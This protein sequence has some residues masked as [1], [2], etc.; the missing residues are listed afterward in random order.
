MKTLTSSADGFCPGGR[1]LYQVFPVLAG[2]TRGRLWLSTQPIPDQPL[3]KQGPA[4]L[5]DLL[6]PGAFELGNGERTRQRSGTWI[7][8]KKDATTLPWTRNGQERLKWWERR[9]C[10]VEK[11]HRGDKARGRMSSPWV[12]K[13]TDTKGRGIKVNVERGKKNQGQCWGGDQDL[14]RLPLRSSRTVLTRSDQSRIPWPFLFCW[15]K[16]N[17]LHQAEKKKYPMTFLIGGIWRE[18][19]QINWQNRSRL[20]GLENKLMVT[21]GK[22]GD[23]G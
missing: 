13:E 10:K 6:S 18:I 19:I 1:G 9:I 3:G 17:L 4:K 12:Q 22:D 15:I 2:W 14:P 23:R 8:S 21:R 7:W 11:T 20:T 5:W 16:K